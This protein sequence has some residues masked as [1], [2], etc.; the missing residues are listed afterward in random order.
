MLIASQKEACKKTLRDVN[1]STSK[2]S[3]AGPE[4]P[5]SPSSPWRRSLTSFSKFSKV[6]P[7]NNPVAQSPAPD[8]NNSLQ[9]PRDKPHNSQSGSK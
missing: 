4:L 7:G 3:V 9:G 8:S 5:D 1:N 6:N 2:K